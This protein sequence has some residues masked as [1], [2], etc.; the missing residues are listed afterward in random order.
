MTIAALFLG[1]ALATSV[2]LQDQ[3]DK[4]ER[5][6]HK[7]ETEA[8]Q[9][10]AEIETAL[11]EMEERL[12]RLG[13]TVEKS[14]QLYPQSVLDAFDADADGTDDLTGQMSA[15]PEITTAMGTTWTIICG[16]LVMFM[17]AGFAL[18]ETGV[19]RSVSCQ[20]I[21]MKNI[22]NVCFGTMIW[23]LF[24]YA[25][26]YGGDLK[27]LPVMIVGGGGGFFGDG[28]VDAEAG[29]MGMGYIG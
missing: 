25:L 5:R 7:Q 20:S 18:L 1:V 14:R 6:L 2:D 23:F 17:H 26:M 21:L 8:S 29:E 19:C 3:V 24:G 15:I 22:L 28:M 11:K 10:E 12:E 27:I 4:L 9:K 16:A 13:A